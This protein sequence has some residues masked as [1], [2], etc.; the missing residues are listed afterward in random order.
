[1]SDKKIA[2]ANPTVIGAFVLMALALVAFAIMA[3]GGAQLFTPKQK[4]VSFFEGSVKGLNV[5]SAVNFRGVKV[6]SVD[7]IV[8]QFDPGSLEPRIPV[9]M[10]LLPNQVKLIGTGEDGTAIPFSAYIEKGLKAKLSIDSLVT[11]Q[12]VVDLDFR[13]DVPALF[14]GARETPYPEI[15][16]MKSDFDVLKDQLSQLPLR[17]LADDV[18]SMVESF[19]V[20]ANGTG[21]TLGVVG[22]ELKATALTTRRT[23][24]EAQATI[25]TL[26]RTLQSFERTSEQA[27][28]SLAASGPEMEATLKS[29]RAAMARV[30]TTMQGADAAVAQVAEMTAPG[31]PIRTELEQ[32]LRDLSAS[33]ESLRH[34]ADT[35]EREPNA[36]IFGKD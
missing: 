25:K 27:R 21:G 34:F 9:Y 22:E 15:P 33:A 2:K 11:G 28:A 1:M 26:N 18:K 23:L 5:G 3:L 8:L 24:E 29:A 36:V 12:L 17:Q 19:R 30:E 35:V 20:L 31:A 32:T 16:S 10:T 4:V 14:H 6:G 7:R 13:P